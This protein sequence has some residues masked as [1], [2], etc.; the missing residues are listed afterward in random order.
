MKVNLRKHIETLK[1]DIIIQID[2]SG[3]S[4]TGKTK[5]GFEV[6]TTETN[7]QLIGY[8]YVGV[9]E[10]GRRGGKV[11]TG[12]RDIL[13]RWAQ[14]KGISF[15]D[16]KQANQWAYFVSKKIQREGTALYRSGRTN[17]IFTTPINNLYKNL[18][19]DIFNEIKNTI[20]D[21]NTSTK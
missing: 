17:D 19:Q 11:P 7:G 16:S 13:L 8:S 4:A 9:L 6:K 14:A 12:F 20:Y 15:S 10:R 5:K 18:E 1:S 2:K 21:S 3:V